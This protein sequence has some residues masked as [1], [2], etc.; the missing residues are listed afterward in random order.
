VIEYYKT[1]KELN[2]QMQ[3]VALEEQAVD[4]LTA[5]AKVKDKKAKFKDIMN[6][7]AK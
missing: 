5:G 1:N 7:E 6:P 4:V 2:Q 3:N